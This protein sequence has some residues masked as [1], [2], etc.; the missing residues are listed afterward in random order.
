MIERVGIVFWRVVCLLFLNHSIWG[1]DSGAAEESSPDPFVTWGHVQSFQ[2]GL[3]FNFRV[4]SNRL[5][6]YFIDADDQLV[7]EPA[8]ARINARINKRGDDPEFVPLRFKS[9][10]SAY[11]NPMFIRRPFIMSV[12][13]SFIGEDGKSISSFQFFM[14]QRESGAEDVA[15]VSSDAY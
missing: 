8:V 3:R 7:T 11:T 14:N 6:V 15:P 5:R 10:L 9:E 2:D 1:Q 12:N 13:M 4:E